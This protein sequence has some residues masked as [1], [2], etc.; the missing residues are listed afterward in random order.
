M[1]EALKKISWCFIS[2][3][4]LFERISYD[5]MLERKRI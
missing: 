1:Q 4:V 3:G 2:D 5:L